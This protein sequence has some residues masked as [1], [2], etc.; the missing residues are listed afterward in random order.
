MPSFAPPRTRLG[1]A[2]LSVAATFALH[3]LVA[4]SLGPRLPA[5]KDQADLSAAA[6]G[7]ALV[8]FA[9]GTFAGTRLAGWPV[10]RFG[11]RAVIRAG[12]PLLGAALVG[13]AVSR[14]LPALALSL[15]ALGLV[16]GL[17]DVAMN[18]NGVGVERRIGRPILSG[19]HGLWSA[20]MLAGAGG[21]VVAAALDV[22]PLGHFAVVAGVIVLSSVPLLRGLLGPRDLPMAADAAAEPPRPGWRA[23]L[24]G[25]V[26]ALGAVGFAAFLAEGA[27]YDWGAVY[28]TDELGTSPAV[29]AA[30]VAAFAFGMTTSRLLGDRLSAAFGPVRVVRAGGLVAAV[31][32]TLGLLGSNPWAAAAGFVVLGLGLAPVVPLAFSAAGHLGSD[33][34]RDEL[35]WVVTMSYVGSILGPA[36]IGLGTGVAGLRVSLGIPVLLALTITALAGYVSTA[37][38]VDPAAVPPHEPF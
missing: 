3:A 28:L 7:A 13:P 33:E 29:A 23:G 1:R 9:A 15:A 11:S 4:G 25:R 34:R 38:R 19:L 18:A 12:T 5:V 32:L 14:N 22:P 6:L 8:G 10:R 20:G 16:A 24:A 21:A 36:A 31:A 27:I 35:G 37:Q 30:G 17:L 2:R 26:L